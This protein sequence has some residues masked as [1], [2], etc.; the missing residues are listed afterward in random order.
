V[1]VALDEP[2]VVVELGP[3]S[4][5]LAEVVDGVVELGPE[6]LFFEGSDEPFGAAVGFRGAPGHRFLLRYRLWS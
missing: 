5:G 3:C 4:D 2:L 6:A 1:L